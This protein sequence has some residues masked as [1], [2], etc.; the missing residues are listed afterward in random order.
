MR[1][2]ADA[3]GVLARFPYDIVTTSYGT[4]LSRIPARE[5]RPLVLVRLGVEVGFH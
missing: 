5:W 1:L 2:V 3:D 4:E